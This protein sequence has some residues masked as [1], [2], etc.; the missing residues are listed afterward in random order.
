MNDIEQRLLGSLL[1]LENAI[2]AMGTANP[3]P[4]LAE[5][6]ARIDQLAAQLPKG[7]DPALL[8]YLQKKS[9]QKARFYLQGRDAEN[10]MGSCGH[11]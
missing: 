9:Y 10:T 8:H 4:N 11:Q 5:H 2:A 3:K 7:T 1:E 6:F